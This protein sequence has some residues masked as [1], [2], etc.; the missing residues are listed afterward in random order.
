SAASHEARNRRCQKKLEIDDD[1][2]LIRLMGSR[3]DWLMKTISLN[4]VL[5]LSDHLILFSKSS[6]PFFFLVKFL[7]FF[8]YYH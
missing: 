8:C 4:G 1:Q 7:S 2:K 3:P 5:Q 6:P